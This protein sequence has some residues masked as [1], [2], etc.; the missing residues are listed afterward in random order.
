MRGNAEVAEAPRLARASPIALDSIKRSRV[1]RVRAARRFAQQRVA[2]AD[3][4]VGEQRGIADRLRHRDAFARDALR[5]PLIAESAVRL[6]RR[7]QDRHA[8]AIE[9]ESLGFGVER[10]HRVERL[11]RR[12]T[13]LHA[14]ALA[15]SAQRERAS[16]VGL[17]VE[18][19]DSEVAELFDFVESAAGFGDMRQRDANLRE[20]GRRGG[21][22]RGDLQIADRPRHARRRDRAIFAAICAARYASAFSPAASK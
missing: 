14:R 12:L 10:E 18:P 5:R 22:A 3:Q 19:L 21:V 1:D 20:L 7:E 17:A 2:E 8:L 13:E 16:F 9:A 4:R 15:H 6:R 11:A